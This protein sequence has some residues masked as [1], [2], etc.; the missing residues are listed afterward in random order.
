MHLGKRNI[1]SAGRSSGSIEVTLPVEFSF[2]VGVGCGLYLR[3]G[4]LPEIVLR[5]D[6]REGQNSFKKIWNMLALGFEKIGQIGDFSEADFL[7]SLMHTTK[8]SSTPVLAYADAIAIFKIPY[9]DDSYR[10]KA[11]EAFARTIESMGTVAG[12]RLGLVDAFSELFGNYVAYVTCGE[13]ADVRDA[14]I[15]GFARLLCDGKNPSLY[16]EPHLDDAYWQS[17]QHDLMIAFD[18]FMAWSL[19]PAVYLREREHWYRA[20]EFEVGLSLVET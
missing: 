15:R 20:R 18:R 17:S 14:F 4:L 3:D 2:L 1:R 10:R 12:K 8:Q 9:E 19:T 6:L 5:P 11:M 7:I 13:I 16:Q